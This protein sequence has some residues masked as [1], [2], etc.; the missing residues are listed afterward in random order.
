MF[1]CVPGRLADHL[2]R[3]PERAVAHWGSTDAVQ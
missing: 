2:A 3:L 1:A